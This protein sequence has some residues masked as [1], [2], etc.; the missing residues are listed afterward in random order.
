[1][2]STCTTRT[3]PRMASNSRK[4]DASVVLVALYDNSRVFCP[5]K[6]KRNDDK[7]YA[8]VEKG[9]GEGGRPKEWE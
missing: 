8:Y 7:A 5:M 1:M 6:L 9:N 4:A 2:K 3:E